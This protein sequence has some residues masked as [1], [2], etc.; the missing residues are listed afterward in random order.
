[1][2]CVIKCGLYTY[3]FWTILYSLLNALY[4]HGYILI[5]QPAYQTEK[6]KLKELSQYL[7]NRVL[8]VLTASAY[9]N[10]MPDEGQ[11]M[12]FAYFALI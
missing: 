10:E 9:Y 2:A 1:M 5:N 12:R 6:L 8:Q 11:I 7:F 3:Y 4:F